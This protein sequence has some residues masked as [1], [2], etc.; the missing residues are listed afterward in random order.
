MCTSV[1][2]SYRNATEISEW[3][4]WLEKVCTIHKNGA[5]NLQVTRA[6]FSIFW[7]RILTPL[8]VSLQLL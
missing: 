8:A 4:N 1:T 2:E 5:Q 3:K 6:E 7:R